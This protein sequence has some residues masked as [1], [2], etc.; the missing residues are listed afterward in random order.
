MTKYL[1]I[2]FVLLCFSCNQSGS[3]KQEAEN[4]NEV[5]LM[6][7]IH[8][9]HRK[10]EEYDVDVVRTL[11]KAIKPDLILAEIPPDRFDQAMKDFQ[12]LDTIVEPRVGRFPE[13]VDVIFPLTKEMDFKIIPTA[14]WTK[15]MADARSVKLKEIS[16]DSSR[17]E[18]WGR[19][20]AARK[21]ADSLMEATGR[22]YDPYFINSDQYDEYSVV[23]YS[24]Y[25]ELFNDELGPGG[26]DNINVSHYSY[27]EKA[28]N[29][30]TNQGKRI[31]ITYGAA[32]KAWFLTK[33]RKRDDIEIIYLKDIVPK[34]N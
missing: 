15:E 17:K 16:Q 14:G 19:F 6:G 4:K 20:M 21:K 18:D 9:G 34:E 33:L 32:H 3:Q 11:I 8:D 24:V 10:Y 29:E 12:E 22:K 26:W 27:I 23:R 2:L 7:M 1:S 28:L 5:L 31:L 30:Y 13:Y 25:N